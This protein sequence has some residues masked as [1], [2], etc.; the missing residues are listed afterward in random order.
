VKGCDTLKTL[1]VLLALVG[2]LV[3]FGSDYYASKKDMNMNLR[4][5]IKSIGLVSVMIGVYLAVVKG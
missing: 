4:I 5:R 1:G 3:V 2:F